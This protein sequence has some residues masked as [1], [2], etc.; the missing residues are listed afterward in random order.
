ME[1]FR[2]RAEVR[3]YLEQ[4]KPEGRVVGFVPT[5][6][7]LHNG[8]LSLIETAREKTDVVVCSIFV[9]PTQFND[10]ADL[11]NYPRPIDDDIKQLEK[12]NCDVLFL[13]EVSEMYNSTDKWHIELDKLDNILEGEIRPGHYQGVTQIVKKL[14][15]IVS[16]D[17][18]FFGQKDFQQFVVISYMVKKLNLDVKLV[19]CPIVREEDG[20]AM[21]SRNVYLSTE[22]RHHALSLFK[23]LSKAKADFGNLTISDIKEKAI[24][25]LSNAEGIQVEYFE[26]YNGNTFEPATTKHADKIIALVAARVGKIRIIDNMIL[27]NN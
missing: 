2:T 9:N 4:L 22:D 12:A 11:A 14:F 6:G 5:M 16:P 15:D 23:A 24:Q 13:P 1:I 25:Y 8:H 19:M 21:S 27:N 3:K 18:A 7:A 10:K 17:Y 26:I 20:L